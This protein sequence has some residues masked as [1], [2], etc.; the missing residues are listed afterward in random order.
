MA[1]AIKN[2]VLHA[3]PFALLLSALAL[4]GCAVDAETV[5]AEESAAGDEADSEAIATTSQA[6]TTFTLNFAVTNFQLK[7]GG[8]AQSA[9]TVTHAPGTTI[10]LNPITPVSGITGVFT[11]SVVG[12]GVTTTTFRLAAASTT[13]IGNYNFIIR[14]SANTVL[15]RLTATVASATSTMSPPTVTVDSNLVP[16]TKTLRA[17]NGVGPARTVG[18]M[19]DNK[20]VT[21]DYVQDELLIVTDDN[22]AVAALA[23][24]WGGSIVRTIPSV[25]RGGNKIPAV[26]LV[27]VD[28][29]RANTAALS[30]DLFALKRIPGSLKISSRAALGTFAIAAKEAR[31]GL[32][33][34]I[35]SLN[36]GYSILT[37]STQD[38]SKFVKDASKHDIKVVPSDTTNAFTWS[39]YNTAGQSWPTVASAWRALE[40]AG[41]IKNRVKVAVVDGGFFAD[42]DAPA[43]PLS[44]LDGVSPFAP[45]TMNC[46]GQ[47]CPFHGAEVAQVLGAKIDNATGTAGVA[48]QIA[49]LVDIVVGQD[50]WA[51]M[52]GVLQ[53]A[54]QGARIVNMSYGKV[55][56]AIAGWTHG[57]TDG[58]TKAVSKIMLLFAAAGNS[59][60]D[61]NDEDC[62]LSECWESA[63]H[64]PCESGGV[65]CV[66][67]LAA[68]SDRRD[69]NSNYGQKSATLY[70]PFTVYVGATPDNPADRLFVVE[71][72]SVSSPFVAGVA[73]MVVAA[74]PSLSNAQVLNIIRSTSRPSPT[75]TGVNMINASEAVRR[76][77]GGNVLPNLE[78]TTPA[79]PISRD[80]SQIATRFKARVDDFEDG[81]AGVTVTWTDSIAGPMGTG[82]DIQFPFLQPGNHVVTAK[83]T[84]RA[85]GTVTRTVNVHVNPIT[86]SLTMAEPA[87]NATFY[88]NAPISARAVSSSSVSLGN[89][90]P[91]NELVWK[92]DLLPWWSFTGCAGTLSFNA[93]GTGTLSVT[94]RGARASARIVLAERPQNGPPVVTVF[95]PDNQTFRFVSTTTYQISG[96]GVAS[97]GSTNLV[98]NW[99]F[100]N[101]TTGVETSLSDSPT[102]NWRPATTF[103]A[104]LSGPP[105]VGELRLYAMDDNGATSFAAHSLTIDSPPR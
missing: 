26:H 55:I 5:D 14:D 52:S 39:H 1:K 20:G 3:V 58:F 95:S 104:T 103:P 17:V 73:A 54:Q 72:T 65:T 37:K 29:A 77:L 25:T 79:G 60:V 46:G 75:E 45:N 94:G 49:D 86:Y 9:V 99:V 41:K 27:R 82:T 13:P 33:V 56:P 84:D 11:P 18:R 23:A 74:N 53:A 19:K 47:P 57:P 50:D 7:Q 38:A 102:F 22:A 97:N 80:P 34:S 42:P 21:L 85:G 87:N 30:G 88:R 81:A 35:N 89:A 64:T 66:A 48:G 63:V 40:M 92:L 100:R 98:Y 31:A 32:N 8:S 28:S 10:T 90:I 71:G 61:V 12:P 68:G 2:I 83:A 62:F 96:I 67:G 105:M 76:A 78:I 101:S 24:R 43:T 15:A 59:G 70:A 6:L 4:D 36:S 16:G 69:P 93:V 44:M 91:C 51:T